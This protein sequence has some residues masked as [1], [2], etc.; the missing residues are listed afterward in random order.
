MSDDPHWRPATRPWYQKRGMNP[1]LPIL[2]IGA[3]VAIF[4]I[5]MIARALV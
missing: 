1:L 5:F 2:A 3:A 4:A